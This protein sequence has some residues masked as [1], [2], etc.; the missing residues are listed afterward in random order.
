[1]KLS[2]RLN[3]MKYS[4]IHIFLT[5]ILTFLW[6]FFLGFVAMLIFV[7]LPLS[8][9][10]DIFIFYVLAGTASLYLTCKPIGFKQKNLKFC[11][12]SFFSVALMPLIRHVLKTNAR[13]WAIY[14][15]FVFGILLWHYEMALTSRIAIGGK[16][17]SETVTRSDVDFHK[18]Q[19]AISIYQSEYN[20][21]VPL[22]FLELYQYKESAY[23]LKDLTL[24]EAERRYR[25]LPPAKNP[26]EKDTLLIYERKPTW[27]FHTLEQGGFRVSVIHIDKEG[28]PAWAVI[29]IP[30][31]RY[32]E[33]L[34]NIFFW[35]FI[36]TPFE[37]PEEIT[38]GEVKEY[39][40]KQKKE[41]EEL[42]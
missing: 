9:A 19:F 41:W 13:R 7:F 16:E 1:M 10:T 25:Y 4:V 24:T 27:H 38:P 11:I 3:P 33:A 26:P 15:L 36:N 22:S 30:K 32:G 8:Y 40:E 2:F 12:L 21:M 42:R 39:Y 31:E 14:L 18:L 17:C 37:G 29:G 35:Y 5:V 20:D 28:R 6:L 34:R 23:F